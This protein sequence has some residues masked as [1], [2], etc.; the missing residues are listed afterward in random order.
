MFISVSES[1]IC[2]ILHTCNFLMIVSH[3]YDKFGNHS[4]TF[5]IALFQLIFAINMVLVYSG[6]FSTVFCHHILADSSVQ[7]PGAYDRPYDTGNSSYNR[8]PPH[9]LPFEVYS[10]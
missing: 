6:L 8:A 1:I 4:I 9:I 3:S 5:N 7:Y 2:N 10:R